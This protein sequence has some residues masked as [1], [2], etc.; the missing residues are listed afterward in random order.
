MQQVKQ[1]HRHTAFTAGIAT[2]AGTHQRFRW[3]LRLSS[4][5]PFQ[6]WVGRPEDESGGAADEQAADQQADQLPPQLKGSL[7]STL[8]HISDALVALDSNWMYT[9]ANKKA[10]SLLDLSEQELVGRHIWQEVFPAK[11]GGQFYQDCQAALA[12]QQL[13]VSEN[14]YGPGGPDQRI[15][16][17][18]IYPSKEGLLI[19]FSDLTEKRALEQKA[20]SAKKQL[21]DLQAALNASAI[22]STSDAEGRISWVN[23]NFCA[24]SQYS[25]EELYGRPHAVFNP[26]HHPLAASADELRATLQRGEIWKGEIQVQAR[27]GAPCGCIQPSPPFWTRRAA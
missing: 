13:R 10:C 16:E 12:S 18:R 20:Q 7:C 11:V 1:G 25:R 19:F 6:V 5:G 23:D 2:V 22:V 3:Q 9:Y 14:P 15:L 8:D 27:N 4:T 24:L 21:E 26:A 17:S